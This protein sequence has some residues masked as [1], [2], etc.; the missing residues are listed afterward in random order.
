MA[1]LIDK[2]THAFCYLRPHHVFGRLTESVHTQIA[3]PE[4]SKIHAVIEYQNDHWWIRDLSSNGTW[5]NHRHLDKHK[6]VK[7]KKGDIISFAGPKATEFEVADTGM[8]RD[9]LIPLRLEDNHAAIPLT[10][11]NLLPSEHLPEYSLV[12]QAQRNQWQLESVYDVLPNPNELKD[13]DIIHMQGSP[14]RL[15]TSANYAATVPISSSVESIQD[16]SLCFNVSQDEE[17]TRLSVQCPD[18]VIDL[19]VRSHHYLSLILARKRIAD[20]QQHINQDSQGWLYTDEL[21]HQLGIDEY[22]ANIQIHR[23]RKQVSDNLTH[24]ADLDRL[25]ERRPGM[26]R[27]GCAN[28]SI[29][30]GGKVE[31]AFTN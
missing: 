12:F 13:G 15:Q 28:I 25:I 24:L 1:Y 6:T 21:T 26:L 5:L 10:H 9:H 19:K 2:Q 8:P 22:H 3:K 7:L 14:W 4:I 29:L 30:K 27:L 31:Y 18:Q 23:F 11:Y 16:L 17:T 20:I